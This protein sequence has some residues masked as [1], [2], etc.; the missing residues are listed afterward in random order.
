MSTL[1]RLLTPTAFTAFTECPHSTTLDLACD[2]RGEKRPR[3]SGEFF[4][5]IT[6]KG[7]EHEEA[8]FKKLEAS[9][10]TITKIPPMIEGAD[11]A[12]EL[13]LEAMRRGDEVI[14]QAFLTLEGWRG[15]ADFLVRVTLDTDLGA[16]GYEPVD[17]KLA[18]KEALPHHI[19]QLTYYAEAIAE[20]K[21]MMVERRV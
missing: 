7:N 6:R 5:L 21:K 9:G 15:A 1:P 8:H 19:L 10:I 11:H 4:D 3:A 13:T 16:W 17:T 18:R 12:R 2:A 14:F 20:I